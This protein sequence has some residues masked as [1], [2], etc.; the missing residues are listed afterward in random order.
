MEGELLQ[1]WGAGSMWVQGK[2]RSRLGREHRRRLDN[3]IGAGL[4]PL[5]GQGVD[6]VHFIDSSGN[7]LGSVPRDALV[8]DFESI[9][10]DVDI[11]LGDW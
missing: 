9:H 11:G 1:Y 7:L 10:A 5:D 8:A 2:P 4:G 6:A 3:E